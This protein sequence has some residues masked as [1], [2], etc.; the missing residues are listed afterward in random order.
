MTSQALLRFTFDDVMT[1][2]F[3]SLEYTTEIGKH[4]HMYNCMSTN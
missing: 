2:H 3:L 1:N 4:N